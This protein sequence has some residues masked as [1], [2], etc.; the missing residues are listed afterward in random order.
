M[1]SLNDGSQA[2]KKYAVITPAVRMAFI[3]RVQS[4]Q[5]TI[6]QAAQEFGIKFSTSKAILQTYRREGRVGKKK[7]RQRRSISKLESLPEKPQEINKT[8][9][10]LVPAQP[11]QTSPID[12]QFQSLQLQLNQ[13]IQL[14]Q[15]SLSMNPYMLLQQNQYLNQCLMQLQTQQMINSQGWQKPIQQT[16]PLLQEFG[17]IQEQRKYITPLQSSKCLDQK[18]D[19]GRTTLKDFI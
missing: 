15:L 9:E 14:M 2:R 1:E 16:Q 7:T 5:S 6:K 11:V 3:K 10:S 8:T 4:K 13:Q 19:E 12:Q 17:R 18:F